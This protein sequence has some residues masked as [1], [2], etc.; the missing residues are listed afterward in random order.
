MAEGLGV[1]N[2]E[3]DRWF[4]RVSS[5]PATAPQHRIVYAVPPNTQPYSLTLLLYFTL[6]V[7]KCLFE[8]GTKK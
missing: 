3:R 1:I 2:V 4:K 7:K 6:P 5:P 8:G